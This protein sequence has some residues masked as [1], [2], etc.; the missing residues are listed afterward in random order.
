MKNKIIIVPILSVLCACTSP[1]QHVYNFQEAGQ[2]VIVDFGTVVDVTPITIDEH[3]TGLGVSGGALVGGGIG[4]A[5]GNGDGKT[6]AV[7]GG[8]VIGAIAG[9]LAEDALSNQEGRLYTIVLKNGSTITSAQYFKKDEPLIQT[10]DRVTVQ[11]SGSYQRV[12]PANHL[13]TEIQRPENI[14]VI[15]KRLN[16]L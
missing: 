5:A 8:A 10:G 12:L 9:G 13:P 3:G 16:C 6:A 2:S 7:V 14:K 4:S 15:D 11:T 1:S